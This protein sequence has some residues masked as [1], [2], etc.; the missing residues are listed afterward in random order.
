[1]AYYTISHKIKNIKPELIDDNFFDYVFLGEN[2]QLQIDE[3]IAN[4]LRA[5]FEYWY[6]MDFR[7]TGKDLIQNHMSFC[8]FNHVAI[9]P[10]NKW[11]VSYGLNGHIM[12]E[13]EKM[14]KSKGNFITMRQAYSDFGA[15]ASRLTVLLS[16]EGVDDANFELKITKSI[17]T[18][19]EK[20]L[21]FSKQHYMKGREKKKQIDIWFEGKI[22]AMIKSAE[23]N[24]EELNFR[25]I[26]QTC[27]F[28]LRNELRWY[29]RRT[30][31]DPNKETISYYIETQAL[32]LAPITPFITEEIWECIGKKDFIARASWPEIIQAE[33]SESENFVKNTFSDIHTVLKLAKIKNPKKISIYIA[34]E[35]KYKLFKF[36]EDVEFN[37]RNFGDI[38]RLAMKKDEFKKHGKEV[39]AIIKN[40]MKAKQISLKAMQKEELVILEEAKSFF[41]KEFEL[42][43]KIEKENPEKSKKNKPAMPSK[44]SI[45]VQ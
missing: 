20:I 6:P 10:E 16:G 33:I 2:T 27:F 45:V 28:E 31:D 38:I 40:I 15:D 12:V 34:S 3:K 1:M 25:E 4:E 9:F 8:I 7:N 5:D 41:E 35:W 18:K 36:L 11:P 24:Y 21:F 43:I 30:N 17:N 29:M 44:P 32:L 19:L 39:L 42:E 13:G 37:E 22:G 26:I 14:A 23:K